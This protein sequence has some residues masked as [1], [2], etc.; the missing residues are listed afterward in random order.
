MLVIAFFILVLSDVLRQTFQICQTHNI[1]VTP[2]HSLIRMIKQLS[3]Q[4]PPSTE[5]RYLL[6]MCYIYHCYAL[7]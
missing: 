3:M 2:S 7:L 5:S 6:T 4:K 1:P